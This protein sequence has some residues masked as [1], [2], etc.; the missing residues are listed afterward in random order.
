VY[1]H[2]SATALL[3]AEQTISG[4][5]AKKNAGF[6]IKTDK[7]DYEATGGGV[8]K[9]EGKKL[10]ATGDVEGMKIEIKKIEAAE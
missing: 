2:F 4:T 3:A 6:I 10:K 1:F 8:D 5:A 9:F 7:G